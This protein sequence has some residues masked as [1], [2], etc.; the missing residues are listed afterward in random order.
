[1]IGRN[2]GE[3]HYPMRNLDEDDKEESG[4]AEEEYK[5][6][7][8]NPHI[9]REIIKE[10]RAILGRKKNTVMRG[11]IPS[12]AV[13][14][15]LGPNSV[16]EFDYIEA[17]KQSIPKELGIRTGGNSNADKAYNDH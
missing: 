1:M 17:L 3:V 13:R 10:A 11:L 5:V 16:A 7:E 6:S 14:E 4:P 8:I 12:T 9:L 15:I 2:L